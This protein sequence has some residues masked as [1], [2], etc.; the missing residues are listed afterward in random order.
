MYNYVDKPMD[1]YVDKCIKYLSFL[2]DFLISDIEISTILIDFWGYLDQRIGGYGVYL[3]YEIL[4][5]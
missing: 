5:I 2:V 3:G 1:N 4:F